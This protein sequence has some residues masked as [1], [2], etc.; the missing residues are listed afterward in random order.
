MQVDR[1]ASVDDG[2]K[3]TASNL[4]VV[5]APNMA[6]SLVSPDKAPSAPDLQVEAIEGAQAQRL[7]ETMITYYNEVR[8]PPSLAH[9]AAHARGSAWLMARGRAR[10]RRPSPG[11]DQLFMFQWMKVQD[12]PLSRKAT[13]AAAASVAAPAKWPTPLHCALPRWRRRRGLPS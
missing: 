12:L 10:K 1:Y 6:R 4:A 13:V 11:A 2:N 9:A 3:M 7:V 8:A 5:F